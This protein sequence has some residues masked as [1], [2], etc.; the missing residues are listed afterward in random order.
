M[1]LL[2]I[3]LVLIV[4]ASYAIYRHFKT[5]RNNTLSS[6]RHNKKH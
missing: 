5:R 2:T 6:G 4:V 1:L 3:C